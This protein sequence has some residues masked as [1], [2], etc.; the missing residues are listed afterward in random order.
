MK[1]YISV[2]LLS[3]ALFNSAYAENPACQVDE[4]QARS[5]LAAEFK[6]KYPDSY[7]TQ[8]MLLD[9]G[10]EAF[11]KLCNIPSDPVSDGI[12]KNLNDRYYPS[13]STIHMLYESN[14]KAYKELNG[15]Q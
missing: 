2:I 14:I 8:K 9:S 15:Q 3:I 11:R 5:D 7:S 12:L 6:A 10:M 1:K 4:T 13:F